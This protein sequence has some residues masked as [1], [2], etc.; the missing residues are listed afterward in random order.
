MAKNDDSRRPL[1]VIS[2]VAEMFDLHPQT[3][4][5]YEREGFIAPARQ[6]NQRKYSDEDIKQLEFIVDLTRKLG[7]NKAG[8]EIIMEMRGRLEAMRKEIEGIM[9]YLEEDTKSYFQGRLQQILI[10]KHE[11]PPNDNGGGSR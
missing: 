5:L 7:V 2:V 11:P 9:D 8:L 1:Y 3:L 10:G 4:R 6:N